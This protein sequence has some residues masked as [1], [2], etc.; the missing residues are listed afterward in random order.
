[1]KIQKLQAINK[2]NNPAAFQR[3]DFTDD[4]LSRALAIRD[5]M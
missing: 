1:M 2:E 5:K 4:S 3:R